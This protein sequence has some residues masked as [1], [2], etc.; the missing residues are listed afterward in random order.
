MSDRASAFSKEIIASNI[1]KM[2]ATAYG[3]LSELTNTPAQKAASAA[4]IAA[5][6]KAAAAKK[7]ADAAAKKKAAEDIA[8]FGG[9]AIAASQFANWGNKYSGG[10][11]KRFAVGGPVIGTD[12]I[13][14]MLTPGEFVMSRYAVESFGVDKMK[15]INSGTYESGSVYNYNLS[16]NVRS[17]ANPE[18]I[19]N[20]VMAK[21]RQIDSLRLR[22]SR[23]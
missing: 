20:T 21:I 22:G 5:E 9:N 4:A 1:N 8:K 23:L 7:A 18:Q 3:H 13:P 11:I 6:A 10:L 17:D 15:A 12:V 14:S 16:V 2:G 19:A